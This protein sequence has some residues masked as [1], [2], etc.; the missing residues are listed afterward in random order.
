[1]N[2]QINQVWQ[3]IVSHFL[4]V[5][6]SLGCRFK[7]MRIHFK[8][9]WLKCNLAQNEKRKSNYVWQ[10]VL[11]VLLPLLFLIFPSIHSRNKQH[12]HTLTTS[13]AM[14]ALN[15]LYAITLSLGSVECAMKI[16]TGLKMETNSKN[17]SND[18]N[19]MT[20]TKPTTIE[21]F[22]PHINYRYTKRNY[23]EKRVS[24]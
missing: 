14:H 5:S 10:C 17:E 13:I 6:I 15:R 1:M 11:L 22:Q 4:F 7:I 2:K 18:N 19:R 20:I 23:Q 3:L 9:I 8:W 24:S 21:P 16:S 12:T